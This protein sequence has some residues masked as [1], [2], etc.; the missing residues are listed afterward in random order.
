[1][2][3]FLYGLAMISVRTNETNKLA[4]S[5][6]IGLAITGKRAWLLAD[7]ERTSKAVFTDG[8]FLFSS[9]VRHSSSRVAV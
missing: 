1:M 6:M 7:F 4:V 8:D 9:H 5:H 2:E 3:R